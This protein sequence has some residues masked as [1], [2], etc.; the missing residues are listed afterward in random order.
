MTSTAT[1]RLR[2]ARLLA[3][4]T[5]RTVAWPAL[6]GGGLVGLVPL[7]AGRLD[8][9]DAAPLARWPGLAALALCLGAAW[10][11]DDSASL[12]VACTPTPLALR[13]LM[14]VAL[15]LPLLAGLWAVELWYA[16]AG[17]GHALFGPAARGALSLEFAAMLAFTLAVS[18]LALRVMP[19]SRGGFAGI[20][21]PFALFTL[22]VVL[23]ARWTLLALP[24]DG[25]WTASHLRWAAIFAVG[26]LILAWTS[27]EP[28]PRARAKHA[29]ASADRLR[30]GNPGAEGGRLPSSLEG[31]NPL[32]LRERRE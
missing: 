21:A 19:E 17:A 30:A 2:Q 3:V 24:A 28:R 5:A 26:M 16:T 20:V 22:A 11:L 8:S 25:A 12:T 31:S 7:V 14:L 29:T 10:I 9:A 32:H 6:L 18:G 27:R 13:R 1:L 23:P 15:A 4:P